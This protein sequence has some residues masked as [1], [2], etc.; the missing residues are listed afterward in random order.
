MIAALLFAGCK[1]KEDPMAS[2][3][4]GIMDET[5]KGIDL[6][7]VEISGTYSYLTSLDAI[8]VLV[9]TSNDMSD[10]MA[11]ESVLSGKS[12]TADVTGLKENTNYYYRYR[13]VSMGTEQESEA[14]KSFTTTGY[15]VPAVTTA[16]VSEITVFSAKCGGEVTDDG[17]LEVTARGVCWGTSPNPTVSDS[18]TTDGSG[19][20]SFTSSITGL[21]ENTTYYVRA[22][23]TNA[24]GIGY[25]E[26][27]SFSTG[28][29]VDLGLPSGLLWAT[30][31]VGADSPE[32][33]GWYF[34]WGSVTVGG[35]PDC[36]WAN[37]P[38]NGGSSYYN[39]TAFSTWRTT[40]LTNNV[41]NPEVDAAT[42]NWGGGW[43]MPTKEEWQELYDNTTSTW[44]IE[45]GVYGRKFTSK[46]DSSKYIFLPAAGDRYGT[47]L[48]YAGSYG[49]Y[50]SSAP[51]S[52]NTSG[53]YGLYFYSGD[54]NPQ[55]NICRYFGYTVRPVCQ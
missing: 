45:N 10:A 44:T 16:E 29:G 55:Y 48:Y 6:T 3:K 9:G 2:N 36:S 18:H 30:C 39:E 47:S 25:G 1:K 21:T 7:R 28:G 40:H 54:V 13:F 49:Y 11:F 52:S 34:M 31:N 24:K 32:D 22:Y 27:K 42:A 43:R 50:W 51:Y 26:Q 23:A 37:C 8:Y 4:V 17:Y 41:L 14:V 38:G 5:V 46:A 53:A 19:T 33:Y 12:F 35:D 20:G 15:S